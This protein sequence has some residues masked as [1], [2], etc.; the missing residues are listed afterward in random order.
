MGANLLVLL[1]LAWAFGIPAGFIFWTSEEAP[2]R[3]VLSIILPCYG[4]ASTLCCL[5]LG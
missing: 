3:A 4:L 1:A 5:L 2:L